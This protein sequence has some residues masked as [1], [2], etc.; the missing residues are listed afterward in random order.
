MR[1]LTRLLTIT[2]CLGSFATP[3]SAADLVVTQFGSAFSGAPYAIALEQGY[4]KDAGVDITGIVAGA[5]GGTT[6]RN[7]MAS[8]LGYGEVVLSAALAGVLEGQDIKIVNIGSRTVDDLVLM[9]KPNSDIRSVSQLAGKKIG[10]SNPKS[11]SEVITALAVE[12]G[13][14]PIDRAQRLALGSLGGTLTALESD[15]IDVAATLYIAMG[16]RSQKYRILLDGAKDLPPMVQSVGV[17]TGDLIRKNPE[18]LRA[19]IEARRKGTDFLYAN[20]AKSIKILEKYFDR[21]KPDV[22]EKAILSLVEIRHWSRGDFEMDRLNAATHGL[23]LIGGLSKEV[24][25]DSVLDKSFLPNDLK[26]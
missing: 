16:A 1:V 22:L 17:A 23:K 6:A 5:G 25:W 7:V 15:S 18:K 3:A 9:V 19:M 14:V 10:F 12:K 8:E 24:V 21:I 20:P 11:L 4:F 2:A 26:K 13:G